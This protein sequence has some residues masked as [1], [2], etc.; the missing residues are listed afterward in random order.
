[1]MRDG[2]RLAYTEWGDPNGRPVVHMHGMPGSRYEHEATADVYASL[3]IRVIT[4]D[5]PGYGLSDPQR[6]RRLADWPRDVADLADSLGIDRFGVTS[7]SGGG[8]YGLACAALIPER[9]TAAVLTGCPGPMQFPGAL[10]NMRF[11]TRTG[12][13]L[14][15]RVP[16]LFEAGATALAGLVRRYPRFFLDQANR[17]KPA[18]DLRLLASPAVTAGA[19]EML[20]EAMHRG[21]SGYVQDVRVLALPWDISIGDIHVPV[22]LWHGTQDTVIPPQ[23]AYYLKAHIPGATL[24][25][26]ADEAHMLMWNHLAEVMR[27]ATAGM[28]LAA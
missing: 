13:W 21:A 1:M 10:R 24:R 25:I 19:V 26:C 4:P 27:E 14:A 22:H 17:D 12:V 18:A 6:G 16:W 15:A 3:G 20:R 8:I 5:R 11:M 23:H 2:R 28:Q 7:L 9:V